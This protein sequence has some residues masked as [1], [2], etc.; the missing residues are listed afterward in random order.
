MQIN[1]NKY[2]LNQVESLQNIDWLL[3]FDK[4]KRVNKNEQIIQRTNSWN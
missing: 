2:L 3:I 4:D 1:N